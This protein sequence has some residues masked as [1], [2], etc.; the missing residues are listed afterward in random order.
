MS[1]HRVVVAAY[2]FVIVVGASA[3]CGADAVP[4]IRPE[5]LPATAPA[6]KAATGKHADPTG[7]TALCKDG[8]YSHS[9]HHSR[10]CGTHGGVDKWLDEAAK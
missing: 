5:Q 4:P 8:S 1:A 10:A 3:V 6:A 2:V 7:A 9:K